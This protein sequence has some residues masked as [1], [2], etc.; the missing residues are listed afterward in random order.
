MPQIELSEQVFR[1]ASD[2]AKANGY[3]SVEAY[4]AEVV[5]QDTEVAALFDESTLTDLDRISASVRD[6]APTHRVEALREH[7]SQKR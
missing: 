3:Q 4:V 1:V 2:H 5:L 6:G 7:F